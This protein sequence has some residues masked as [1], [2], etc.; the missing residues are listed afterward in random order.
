MSGISGA[1][2]L[3]YYV[4]LILK[5]ADYTIYINSSQKE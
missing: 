4:F 3:S 1:S 2:R 5:I